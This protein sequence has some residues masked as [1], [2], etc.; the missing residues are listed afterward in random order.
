MYCT[1]CGKEI[2]D[3]DRFCGQCGAATGVSGASAGPTYYGPPPGPPKKLMLSR[4]ERK[5]GGVCAGFADYLGWDVTIVRLL[6]LCGVVYSMGLALVAY[7]I[8]WIVIPAPPQTYV[9]PHMNAVPAVRA[10]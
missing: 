10:T 1:Q 9:Q 2:R 6:F 7:L 4:A 8:A 3:L 5:V